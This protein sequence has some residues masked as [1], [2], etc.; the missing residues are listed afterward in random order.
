MC[1]VSD[2]CSQID[3][4]SNNGIAPCA[5]CPVGQYPDPA[6]P[7]TACVSCAGGK[8]TERVGAKSVDD[9]LGKKKT[10]V[11]TITTTKITDSNKITTIP[12]I[13]QTILLLREKNY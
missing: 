5:Q 9:C 10:T 2:T 7:A 8:S 1:A 13:L 3:M 12:P 11:A 4:V 6:N